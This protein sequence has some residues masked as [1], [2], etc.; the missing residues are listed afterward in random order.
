MGIALLKHRLPL[1]LTARRAKLRCVCGT[2]AAM[3]AGQIGGL[4]MCSL[5]AASPVASFGRNS[6]T[7]RRSR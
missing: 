7:M 3:C 2:C 5:A 1:T 6:G 4:A